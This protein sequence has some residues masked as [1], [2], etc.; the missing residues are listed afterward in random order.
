MDRFLTINDVR[1][2]IPF[3][4]PHIYRLMKRGEFPKPIKIGISR[5]AW[6]ESD[7]RT[8]MDAKVSAG[9]QSADHM[10]S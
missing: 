1:Q 5:V 4:Q 10:P 2:L 7:I 6:R 9:D 3:C 8:W